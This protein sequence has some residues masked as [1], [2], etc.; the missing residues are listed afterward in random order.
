MYVSVRPVRRRPVLGSPHLPRVVLST[1]GSTPMRRNLQ[2]AAAPAPDIEDTA[3]AVPDGAGAKERQLKII[4][5]DEVH[6]F[7]PMHHDRS[8]PESLVE[9]GE[10]PVRTQTSDAH[11]AAVSDTSK[12]PETARVARPPA[13]MQGSRTAETEN[14][15]SST[16]QRSERLVVEE[17]PPVRTAASD[18]GVVTS[19]DQDKQETRAAR[20]TASTQGSQPAKVV[21]P[22]SSK[23]QRSKKAITADAAKPHPEGAITDYEFDRDIANLRDFLSGAKEPI[24]PNGTPLRLFFE[25]KRFKCWFAEV[26]GLLCMLCEAHFNIA[27]GRIFT[28]LTDYEYQQT[29]DEYIKHKSI[30]DNVGG[31][32]VV[33]HEVKLPPPL[34]NRDYVYYRKRVVDEQAGVYKWYQRDLPDWG[35]SQRAEVKGVIRAGRGDFWLHSLLEKTGEDSCRMIMLQQD[36]PAGDVPK[37]AMNFVTKKGIPS[38]FKGVEE[39]AQKLNVRAGTMTEQEFKAWKKAYSST[40]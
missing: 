27:V 3:D 20:T 5:N 1:L 12:K 10:P 31:C 6:A 13:S 33:F 21:N 25:N 35:R 24:H 32:E 9:E 15:R 37:W 39:A 26:N 14:P 7:T 40:I 17:E 28:T 30:I 19:A 34:T 18:E 2:L 11:V 29:Y 22:R 23:A 16:A 38:F 4:P 36:N 8:A